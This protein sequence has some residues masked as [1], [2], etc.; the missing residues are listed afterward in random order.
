MKVEIPELIKAGLPPTIWGKLLSATPVIMTVLATALAGLSS[1]E[2]TRAQYDR[3]LAAQLQSKAGDQWNFFQA[4]R[5]RAALQTNSL[6]L[7][8]GLG[9]VRGLSAELLLGASAHP[10]SAG[11]QTGGAPTES[12]TA[13]V[14][15][16]RFAGS[17][18]LGELFKAPP[19]A[20]GQGLQKYPAI[21]TATAAVGA[22][23]P[24]AEVMSLVDAIDDQTLARALEEA[25]KATEQYDAAIQP[26]EQALA[27]L[28]RLVTRS[29][30]AMEP[31]TAT[32]VSREFAVLRFQRAA[33]RYDAE[34]RLNQTIASLYEL[35][36]RKANHSAERHH[37]RSQRFFYGML[38][39]QMAVIISTLA[40][41]AR[42]RSLLWSLAAAAGLAAL[43]FALYVYLVL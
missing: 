35:Q 15:L 22:S 29:R 41:A 24:E 7:L 36:V 14:E 18:Q 37:D 39:A 20:P 12:A 33:R 21:A 9:E 16:H 26:Q 8:N 4:K 10:A 11:A 32:Q 17:P 3:G 6:D 27:E 38:G 31:A 19:E 40:L 1:S 43:G 2:M 42:Q 34:A 28:A 5:L 13:L 30:S 23:R 25:I